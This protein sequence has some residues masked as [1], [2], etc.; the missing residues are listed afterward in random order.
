MKYEYDL[1]LKDIR[2]KIELLS[3]CPGNSED[4][5]YHLNNAIKSL[6]KFLNLKER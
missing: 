6:D 5:L 1:V 2:N 4:E 3:K